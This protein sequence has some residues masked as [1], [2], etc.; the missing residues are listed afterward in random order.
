M[1]LLWITVGGALLFAQEKSISGQA[2]VELLPGWSVERAQRQA[3]QLAI[4]NAIESAFPTHVARTS[5]YILDNRVRGQTAQTH[6]Y[7][8]LT[9]D[10]YL[11]GEW[12][13]TTEVRYSTEV[14][15]GQIWITCKVKGKARPRTQP[16]LPLELK[17]LRCR[18]TARCTSLDFIAGDP[19]YLYFRSPV[20]GYL[21]VFWEDSGFVFRLLP[22]QNRRQNAEYIRA[23]S[24]YMFFAPDK[25]SEAF[26]TDELILTAEK[27]EVL[28]RLYVVF[29]PHPL[30]APPEQYDASTG[31][32]RIS[33][34][35]FQEWLL[36]ERLRMPELNLR[37]LDLSVRQK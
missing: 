17:T 28:H 32:H 7:F 12:L 23:D 31:F 14:R 5:K 29:S 8:Y 19:L 22:Y 18:D 10:Q 20:P 3:L 4:L 13:Q 36:S 37:L 33:I 2:E 1:R 35:A 9:A 27:P 11:S 25:R 15:K 34:D 6:S 24:S 26:W 30:S 21:Q 16:A